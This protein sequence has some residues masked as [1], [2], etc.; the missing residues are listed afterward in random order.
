MRIAV[1]YEN[2][3]VFQH[4]GHTEQFKIF[5]VEDGK[6]ISSDVVSTNGQ[7]HGALADLLNEIQTDVIICGGIGAGAKNALENVGIKMFGGVTGDVDEA[8]EDY[9]A[10]TLQYN[11][12]IKCNHHSE[13]HSGNC[14]EHH[15]CGHH[16]G[17]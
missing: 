11:P 16:C 10:G 9:L 1:T 5:D 7:G 8:V 14:G 6:I 13:G 4:F 12:D 15:D 3:Q 17:E 2:G